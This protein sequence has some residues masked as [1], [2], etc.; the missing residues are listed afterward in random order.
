MII[1][2]QTG[3]FFG[4]WYIISCHIQSQVGGR[5]LTYL[6]SGTIKINE[7]MPAFGIHTNGH[8]QNWQG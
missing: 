8:S 4:R 2:C 6:P 3:D 7:S 1:T 5:T